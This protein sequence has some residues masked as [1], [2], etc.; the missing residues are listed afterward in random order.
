MWK[1]QLDDESSPLQMD[2][3][4]LLGLFPTLDISYDPQFVPAELAQSLQMS[5][6]SEKIGF[7]T[8]GDTRKKY[9]LCDFQVSSSWTQGCPWNSISS[10]K[11]LIEIRDTISQNS[12]TITPNYALINIYRDGLDEIQWHADNIEGVIPMSFIFS[13]TL[14]TERIF[15]FRPYLPGN[16]GRTDSWPLIS[17]V[18]QHGSKLVMGPQT[19]EFWVCLCCVF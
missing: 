4:Q 16:R 2:L 3:H 8:E 11:D 13:I 6:N 19:N 7:I 5:L 12:S 18:L 15:Q 1:V 14:G 9:A 10:C 17:V